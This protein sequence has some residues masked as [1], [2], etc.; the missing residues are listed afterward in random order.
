M[1]P[2][3]EQ[4]NY[5]LFRDA[6]SSTILQNIALDT[7]K[8][9]RR[10]KGRRPNSKSKDGLAAKSELVASKG[11]NQD[12]PPTNDAEDLS[13]FIDVPLPSQPQSRQS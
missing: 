5:E 1:V 2:D 7:P 9:R 11:A 3:E 12:T 6:L 13:E 4:E 10:A 8:E